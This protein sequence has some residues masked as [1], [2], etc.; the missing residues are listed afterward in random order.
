MSDCS[1]FAR[2]P[3][4]LVAEEIS[5][6][7]WM[8]DNGRPGYWERVDAL[9]EHFDEIVGEA[10]PGGNHCPFVQE[11]LDKIEATITDETMDAIDRIRDWASD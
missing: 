9:Y 5:A 4:R 3:R 1:P 10:G 6:L 11:R 7:N 2:R 8:R